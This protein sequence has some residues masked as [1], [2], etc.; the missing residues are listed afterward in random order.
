MFPH[1]SL[2][3]FKRHLGGGCHY[4]VKEKEIIS[5][6]RVLLQTFRDGRSVYDNYP[7]TEEELI[8]LQVPDGYEC[9]LIHKVA[10]DTFNVCLI[11]K[12]FEGEVIVL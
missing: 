2:L 7:R 4:I 9:I 3:P 6:I 12:E 5:M 11:Q 10:K 1:L 8:Q